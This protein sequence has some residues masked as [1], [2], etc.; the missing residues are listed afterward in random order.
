MYFTLD[1]PRPIV[2]SDVCTNK[3]TRYPGWFESGFGF[4][5][6]LGLGLINYFPLENNV[7]T[8]IRR[9]STSTMSK[10]KPTTLVKR[11][12]AR[13][14]AAKSAA[15]P[16]AAAA[17]RSMRPV[18]E[19]QLVRRPALRPL[20]ADCA[21]HYLASLLDPENVP[22]ACLPVGFPVPSRKE[23]LWAS[24]TLVTGDTAASTGG[25]ICRF[26]LANNGNAVIYSTNSTTYNGVGFPAA[27]NAGVTTASI[28][29]AYS[30]SG[31]GTGNGLAQYRVVSACLKVRYTG[32]EDAM[33]GTMTWMEQAD[34]ANCD[35]MSIGNIRAN[36]NAVTTKV[37]KDWQQINYSG[38]VAPN[39]TDFGILSGR[40]YADNYFIGCAISNGVATESL[41]FDWEFHVNVEWIGQQVPGKTPSHA[42]LQGFS[43]VQTAVKGSSLDAPLTP[44]DSKN[45]VKKVA[46]TVMANSPGMDAIFGAAASLATSNA[47]PIISG[48]MKYATPL[49]ISSLGGKGA[50]TA[51]A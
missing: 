20:I 35:G 36:I 24:G 50:L 15:K 28:N 8:S 49:I 44:G 41:T 29:S 26:N 48:V 6:G 21:S 33:G 46:E 16:K 11:S 9:L 18:A 1:K 47:A 40:D 5:L 30:T 34:H 38:P 19:S 13:K 23:H 7:R 17:S 12:Y 45:V 42:D 10:V 2:V 4:F 51:A 14:P 32:R 3:Y 22:G 27:A 37:S 31:I 25:V 43:S 39:E